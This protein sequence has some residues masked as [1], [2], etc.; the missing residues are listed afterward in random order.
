MDS[1]NN[2]VIV[3]MQFLLP[4]FVSAW[5]FYA[6]TS[7]PKQSQFERLIQALIFTII[8]QAFLVLTKLIIEFYFSSIW[9]KNLEL[10]S[11]F[12]LALILGL[13]LAYFSNNDKFH[14]LL[15][16]LKITKET[17]Y[18]SE[19]FSAFSDQVTYV[20][21]HLDDGRRIY[22]WPKEWPTEP[23]QGHFYLQDVSW[24]TET[25]EEIPL[26]TVNGIL[27]NGEN[28]SLVEFMKL[29]TD[30]NYEQKSI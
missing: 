10:L 11:A 5:V 22:G 28:V 13:V 2:E 6:L 8:V 21:L 30:E 27:V 17:S 19:W 1:L 24:L 15:R 16:H 12:V 23:C 9:N 7:H 25:N 14:K 18:A 26:E 20:V 4:G 3:T 29:D